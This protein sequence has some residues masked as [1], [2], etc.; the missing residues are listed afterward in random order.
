MAVKWELARKEFSHLHG[1][2]VRVDL[3]KDGDYSSYDDLKLKVERRS[4]RKESLLF[5]N[6]DTSE[7]LIF[8]GTIEHSLFMKEAMEIESGIRCAR[9]GKLIVNIPWEAFE[10]PSLDS[11]CKE[12]DAILEADFGSGDPNDERN[13]YDWLSNKY[14]PRENNKNTVMPHSEI[15]IIQ[16]S[17]CYTGPKKAKEGYSLV[18][19]PAW[20]KDL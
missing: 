7:P 8:T 11:L 15:F 1:K 17:E 12:C 5:R 19:N 18:Y 13:H 4:D 9:C 10:K 14:R 2:T 16:K 3:T 6:V 20:W